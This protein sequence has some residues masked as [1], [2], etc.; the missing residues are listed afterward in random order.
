M[1]LAGLAAVA[2]YDPAMRSLL[3]LRHAKSSWDDPALDD[4]DRP[5]AARGLRAA[6]AMGA[7]IARC[8]WAPDAALVSPATRAAETWDNAAAEFEG[9]VE[10]VFERRIYLA[11][12][13]TLL[14]I[15]RSAP[16][17]AE[18]IIMIGHNPGMEDFA[19][20][21]AGP[22]SDKAALA[23]M[24]EKF[25]TAA[26]ARFAFDGAWTALA[27]GAAQLTHFIRPRELG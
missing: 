20:S 19:A 8:G 18:T 14:D 23:R 3:L 24:L 26:L 12:S 9:R 27:P 7:E 25:P 13:E 21:L 22:G 10:T 17:A 15:A 2:A 4:F 6:P 16:A 1:S 5:L 11:T